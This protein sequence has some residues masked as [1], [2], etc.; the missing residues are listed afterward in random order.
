MEQKTGK[1]EHNVVQR[2]GKIHGGSSRN[3]HK[4]INCVHNRGCEIMGIL[5]QRCLHQFG[6]LLFIL[7]IYLR[8]L[9]NGRCYLPQLTSRCLLAAGAAA[10][11]SI[12]MQHFLSVA[13]CNWEPLSHLQQHE[14]VDFWWGWGGVGGT[15]PPLSLQLSNNAS[16]LGEWSL[17]A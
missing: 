6:P 17:R 8:G 4:A 2:G 16:S 11:L 14:M 12:K 3:N 15:V 13:P 7:A 1:A 10:A 9:Q 5:G